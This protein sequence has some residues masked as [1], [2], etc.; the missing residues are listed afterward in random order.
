M[1]KHTISVG[2]TAMIDDKLCYFD[3]EGWEEIKDEH[4][5]TYYKCTV[6]QNT[7][8]VGSVIIYGTGTT[9]QDQL[10]FNFE[11]TDGIQW[12]HGG[13]FTIPTGPAQPQPATFGN[14]TSEEVETVMDQLEALQE[15]VN[16]LTEVVAQ[17]EKL[18][19]LE[20]MA[21]LLKVIEEQWEEYGESVD[22]IKDVARQIEPNDEHDYWNQLRNKGW[23]ITAI[24]PSTFDRLEND[25]CISIHEE[26]SITFV[27]RKSD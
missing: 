27:T 13:G 18:G 8:L 20:E 1:E 19:S 3:G 12:G 25:D 21:Q 9:P 11:G 10:T 14:L 4:G 2:D 6:G 7:E 15:K 22:F 24:D 16:E 23:R 26:E 5:N 17:Y